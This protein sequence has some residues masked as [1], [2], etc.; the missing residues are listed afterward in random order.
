MVWP[1]W[2]V[3][4][5]AGA[6]ASDKHPDR[7]IPAAVS[8]GLVESADRRKMTGQGCSRQA[9]QENCGKTELES[10]I[11]NERRRTMIKN[12]VFDMG[13]VL[14]DYESMRACRHF[15][16]NEDDQKLVCSAVFDSHEWILLDMGLISEEEG[17]RRCAPVC[18]SGCRKPQ[19]SASRTGRNTACGRLT[20]WRTLVRELRQRD[21][22][23]YLF[24]RIDSSAIG[25]HGCD[26]G[27]GML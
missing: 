9:E 8:A 13:K 27:S 4:G 10:L 19:S 20:P 11:E 2:P 22:S 15:L 24:Q 26:S 21:M 14:L 6:C 16:E 3:S 23:L 18:R 17:L 7:E 1:V 5:H 12:I 25:L